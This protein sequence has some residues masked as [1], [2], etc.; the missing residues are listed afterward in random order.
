MDEIMSR[1][2]Q[3]EEMLFHFTL[4]SALYFNQ[5][6]FSEVEQFID[7]ILKMSKELELESEDVLFV[8]QKII[9]LL[10]EAATR[11]N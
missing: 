1:L 3:L 11:I 4:S 8:N 10:E 2:N 9:S 6:F 5:K 7:D